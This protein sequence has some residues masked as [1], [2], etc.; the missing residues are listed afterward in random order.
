MVIG[1]GNEDA[2]EEK[3]VFVCRHYYKSKNYFRDAGKEEVVHKHNVTV[4]Q[5]E[6]DGKQIDICNH[7]SECT[8]RYFAV[9]KRRI[10]CPYKTGS[11]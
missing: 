1:V 8:G 4:I 9:E 7:D 2:A 3:K 5:K 10:D 6:E 11:D